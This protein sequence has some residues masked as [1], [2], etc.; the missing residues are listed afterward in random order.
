MHVHV[1]DVP[2][3]HLPDDEEEGD[4]HREEKID[5]GVNPDGGAR[6]G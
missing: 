2:L 1:G 3:A 6:S 5:D 4:Q